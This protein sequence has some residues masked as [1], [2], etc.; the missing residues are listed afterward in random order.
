[1]VF[2]CWRL[3]TNRS[4][5]VRAGRE[6]VPGS[7]LSACQGDVPDD[8]GV[9][10]VSRN[11]TGDTFTGDDAGTTRVVLSVVNGVSSASARR[12]GG[13]SSPDDRDQRSEEEHDSRR[14][15]GSRKLF[16]RVQFP[17]ADD[18]EAG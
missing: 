10:Y 4:S 14:R 18:E 17:S 3:C 12:D 7:T 11:V 8:N 2:V 1:M 15:H 13:V 9:G 6:V 5:G 16:H